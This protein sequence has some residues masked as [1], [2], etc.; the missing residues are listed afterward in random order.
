MGYKMACARTAMVNDYQL[1]P[2]K[3]WKELF[4]TGLSA[5]LLQLL[6]LL[7]AI[8]V[9]YFINLL[10]NVQIKALST[11]ASTLTASLNTLLKLFVV[12]CFL[13]FIAAYFGS[14]SILNYVAEGK[15]SA[16]F[17]LNMLKR[18]LSFTYLK[19]WGFAVI[20][21]IAL[22]SLFFALIYALG[23]YAS[24]ILIYLTILVM[25]VLLFLPGITIWTLLGEA[26]GKLIVKEY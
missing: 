20:Y 23:S 25:F 5:R 18:A 19:G 15:I 7:P 2:W 12:L 21:S 22:L 1:P 16:A 13:L 17:S 9:F 26:W 14:A 10:I 8:G 11:V 6:Y 4:V 24:T 3:N